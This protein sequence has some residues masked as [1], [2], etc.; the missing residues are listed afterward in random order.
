[1]SVKHI[2][3]SIDDKAPARRVRVRQARPC[4]RAGVRVPTIE[5]ADAHRND[6]VERRLSGCQ[7]EVLGGDLAEG[8]MA[9]GNRLGGRR[10]RLRN[11][12]GRAVDAE[13]LSGRHAHSDRARKRAWAA[14]NFEYAQTGLQRQR[15]EY[16]LQARRKRG[17]WR[18]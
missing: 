12:A 18:E 11:G 16:L 17:A 9:C 10:H 3:Q 2:R 7:D 4:T 8:H 5:R 14:A 1:M 6:Q 15:V 13:H